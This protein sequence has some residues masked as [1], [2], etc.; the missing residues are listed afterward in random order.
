MS[1]Q[2][3]RLSVVL[4]LAERAAAPLKQIGTASQQTA[5]ALKD[6]RDK[7]KAL[8]K[9]QRDLKGFQR[10]RIEL[11][12]QTRELGQVQAKAAQYSQ[13]LAEQREAVPVSSA[14]RAAFAKL[15]AGMKLQ[16]AAARDVGRATFE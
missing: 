16:L 12:Q 1:E 9:V 4:S 6:A 13:S 8:E 7:L 2:N 3:L 5:G 15:A 14:G 11:A 10:S